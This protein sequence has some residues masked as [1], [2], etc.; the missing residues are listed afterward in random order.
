V[1]GVELSGP[2]LSARAGQYLKKFAMKQQ[3]FPYP[4]S[5]SKEATKFIYYIHI[6]G[7]EAIVVLQNP[8]FKAM[9]QHN[10]LTYNLFQSMKRFYG[11]KNTI[12]KR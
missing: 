4:P 9:K 8:S 3:K 6:S 10:S 12:L 5:L 11:F 7:N 2:I 1:T